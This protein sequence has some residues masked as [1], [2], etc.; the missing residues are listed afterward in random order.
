[1]HSHETN[2]ECSK[3]DALLYLFESNFTKFQKNGNTVTVT[4]DD[5]EAKVDL[6]TMVKPPPLFV[7][8]CTRLT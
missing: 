6:D 4:M 8:F 1:M 3:A 2:G 7:Y 5:M